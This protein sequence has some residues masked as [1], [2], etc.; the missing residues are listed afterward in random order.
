MKTELLNEYLFSQL[1]ADNAQAVRKNR[2]NKMFD[3]GATVEVVLKEPLTI[4][5]LTEGLKN[6]EWQ[7]TEVLKLKQ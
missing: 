1:V 5:D 3:D 7:R 2:M 6:I 4:Q